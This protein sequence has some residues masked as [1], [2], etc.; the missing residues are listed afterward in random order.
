MIDLFDL[1]ERDTNSDVLAL[2]N[3]AK[4]ISGKKNILINFD[5]NVR[6]VF[7]DCRA[8]FMPIQFKTEIKDSQGLVSHE[9]GHIGYGSFELGFVKLIGVLAKKHH[10]NPLFAKHLVNVI[11]DVRINAINDKKFPGFYCYLKNFETTLLPQIK[12]K[13]D[14][15]DD[16]LSYIYLFMEE[17]K[18]FQSRPTLKIFNIS[19][20]DW[21][22]ISKLK[23]FLKKSLSPSAS[24]ISAY[25]ICKILKK[26]FPKPKPKPIRN[27]G[28]A[29]GGPRTNNSTFNRFIYDEEYESKGNHNY[30]ERVGFDERA[31]EI[32]MFESNPFKQL[33]EN[34]TN[35]EKLNN[36]LI[37]KLEEFDLTGEELE[38]FL[39]EMDEIE[40][41]FDPFSR[42][43]PIEGGKSTLEKLCEELNDYSENL[44]IKPADLEQIINDIEESKEN[45]RDF[46]YMFSDD[47]EKTNIE[48]LT[49]ELKKKYKDLDM[50]SRELGQIIDDI[51]GTDKFKEEIYENN[52]NK[53]EKTKIEKFH[54]ELK[55]KYSN[56]EMGADDLRE[57]FENLDNKSEFLENFNKKTLG[58][59]DASDFE[60]LREELND[61]FDG[62]IIINSHEL[63]EI[64]KNLGDDAE[65]N[66]EFKDESPE[67][68]KLSDLLADGKKSGRIFVVKKLLEMIKETEEEMERRLFELEMGSKFIKHG[69]SL[70]NRQI[71]DVK[72]ENEKMKPIPLMYREILIQN[73]NVIKRIKQ[74]FTDLKNQRGA[75]TYQKKGR[76]NSK[77]VRTVLSD[78]KYKQCFT[79]KLKE[80]ELRLL[81][82]VD[83]SGSMS[84]QKMIAAKIAMVMICE[85]LE[86]LAKVR[87]VLF[88]GSKDAINIL[89][90]DFDEPL[91][92]KKIDKF[93][94]HPGF[95]SNLDGVS[96]KHEATKLD[97]DDFIIMI[98]DGQPAGSSYG[99]EDAIVEIHDVKKVH[100]VFAFSIDA[101]G[102]YLTRLYGKFWT[103]A[104]STNKMDLGQKMMKICQLIVKEFFK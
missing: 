65:T 41:D 35:L 50:D 63:A 18:D 29:S 86:T 46:P 81:V 10:I 74:L 76:L 62:N 84:G 40:K 51:M 66:E 64:L 78:Y 16:I 49:D 48:R 30:D 88:T 27:M 45:A 32:R 96:M 101:Q 26:Y 98:S 39:N 91:N 15:H 72:I 22:T 97:K 95:G 71:F 4:R 36:E 43:N 11:E 9:A 94:S 59:M 24:I 70:I 75:D 12:Q 85:A 87:I 100:K 23:K 21:K 47:D 2:T 56:L 79:R 14:R 77:F 83:I 73:S 52:N 57:I 60:T 3:I 54:D 6:A 93:G 61:K 90:K 44:N 89:V 104:N 25:Q 31:E 38:D 67:D 28:A 53:S 19:K 13:I 99:L 20:H 82:L 33:T 42:N 102:E 5:N 55:K 58:E 17:Y 37:D 7:T 80:K 69:G 8:I 92:P 34:D 103:L 1:F 68:F